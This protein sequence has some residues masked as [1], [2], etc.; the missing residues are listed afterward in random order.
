MAYI[1]VDVESDGP[2]P[3]LFSMVCFGAV[4][5]EP[6]LKETFY[7]KTAPISLAFNPEALAISGFT[8]KQ[9]EEFKDANI[10][11][12]EFYKWVKEVGGK[13]PRFI[14]DCLTG[15]WG[16]INYYF[17]KY[18]GENP[19]G[20]SGRRLSDLI[21]G[22]NKDMH[23]KWK[24]KKDKRLLHDPVFDAIENAKIFLELKKDGLK[25]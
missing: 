16:F 12:A 21:C 15:D 22:F 2:A 17:Y 1:M 11:I 25:T 18:I 9:H 23:T 10:A 3:G 7:G 20:Y 6:G 19:F 5:V 14:S 13:N 8:R 24:S 4:V